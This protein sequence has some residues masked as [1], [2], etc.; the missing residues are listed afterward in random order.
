[1]KEYPEEFYRT[2]FERTS[3]AAETVLSIV[4]ESLPGVRS[5]VDVGCGV[6]T[7]LSV[8]GGMGVKKILGYDG[9]WVERKLLVIPGDSFR[10]VRLDT[11][12]SLP[13]K[14]DLA[15][16]LE[17]AEHLPPDRAE[18]F[19]SLLAGL[20]DNVLFSAAIPFQG[21]TNHVN[22]RWQGYWA[23]LFG[24]LGYGVHDPV[25]TRIWNDREIPVWYRQN[26]L[27]FMRR[28]GPI[29]CGDDP[30]DARPRGSMPLD[31]VHPDLYLEKAGRKYGI[32]SSLKL[33]CRAVRAR[34]TRSR[35]GG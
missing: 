25:R 21:G 20:S 17:V 35:H 32:S 28:P 26:V 19:V 9:S 6:G 33:L 4:L 30:I 29:D 31:V 12:D 10:E 11:V 23:G 22:E 15:I 3:H 5:A 8:L 16:S 24:A 34:L 1:M 13:G 27:L 7:W 2:R 18:T 14:Y